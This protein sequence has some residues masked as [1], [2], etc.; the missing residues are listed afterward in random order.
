MTTPKEHVKETIIEQEKD[1][2]NKEEKLTCD[3]CGEPITLK[4]DDIEV[5]GEKPQNYTILVPDY[6]SEKCRTAGEL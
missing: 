3:S 1:K 5:K 6:C 4:Q 2:D